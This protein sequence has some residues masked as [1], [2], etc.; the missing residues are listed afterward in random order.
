MLKDGTK[1][2]K[3]NKMILNLIILAV[4]AN[5]MFVPFNSL[6]APLTKEVLNSGEEMLSLLSIA[7]SIGMLLSTVIFP[8]A[9]RK[10]SG[11]TIIAFGGASFGVFYILLVIIGTYLNDS[12][13]LLYSSVAIITFIAGIPFYLYL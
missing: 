1:Y 5:A 12:V 6:Q 11:K 3:T 9:I 8:Y 2:V 10:L 4:L 13:I 7:M